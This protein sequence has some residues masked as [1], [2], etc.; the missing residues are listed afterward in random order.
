MPAILVS[1]KTTKIILEIVDYDKDEEDVL[2]WCDIKIEIVNEFFNYSKIGEFLLSTEVDHLIRWLTNAI[3]NSLTDEEELEFT[4]PELFFKFNKSS[5][6][7]QYLEFELNYS[8]NGCY[9][10]EKWCTII[11]YEQIV[12]LRDGLLKE[13]DFCISKKYA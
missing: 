1:E 5:F 9:G 4:E 11:D 13:R 8:S 6:E 3:N 10:Y 2:S 7:K 12:E